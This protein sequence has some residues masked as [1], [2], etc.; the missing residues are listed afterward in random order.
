MQQEKQKCEG[1][2]RNHNNNNCTETI[3]KSVCVQ[4][5]DDDSR[6]V[7]LGWG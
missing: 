7:G 6:R 1:S 4:V 2:A 5:V 3:T